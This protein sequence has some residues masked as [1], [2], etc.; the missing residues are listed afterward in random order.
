MHENTLAGRNSMKVLSR[1]FG[2][3]LRRERRNAK[4]R[5]K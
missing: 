2:Y 3:M 4:G 1:L 5:K